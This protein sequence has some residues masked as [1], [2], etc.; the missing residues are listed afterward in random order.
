MIKDLTLVNLSF[1]NSTDSEPS[2][3]TQGTDEL[4]KDDKSLRP[5]HNQQPRLSSDVIDSKPI[6]SL[7]RLEFD[8]LSSK[9]NGLN[10]RLAY[11]DKTGLTNTEEY[12]SI[13]YQH[14]NLMRDYKLL[15]DK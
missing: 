8:N 7:V 5:K 13:K 12:L 10:S 3:E 11:L 9:L 2:S 6:P 14:A 1:R 15:T 4:S